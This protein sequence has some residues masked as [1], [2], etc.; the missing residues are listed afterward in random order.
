MARR[1]RE[2]GR[3]KRGED[4]TMHDQHTEVYGVSQ[5]AATARTPKRQ[6]RRRFAR[7]TPKEALTWKSAK[8]R[9]ALLFDW[10]C[11]VQARFKGSSNALSVAWLL[12]TL[13]KKEG[14]AYAT[15]SY[16]SRLTGIKINKIQA[17]VTALEKAGA[18]VR[19]SV[20]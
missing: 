8:S 5:E 19:G 16:I 12:C 11:A 18:I 15:D 2:R 14:Y 3:A 1:S 9:G 20:F 13:C 10:Q 4:Q 7:G 17:T 6:H